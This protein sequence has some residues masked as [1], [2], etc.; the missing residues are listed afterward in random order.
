MKKSLVICLSIFLTLTS[1]SQQLSEASQRVFKSAENMQSVINLNKISQTG[2]TFDTRYEGVKGSP[3]LAD[4]LLPSFLKLAG[5]DYYFEI[6][7]DLD[8]A[9][10]ALIY[11]GSG[12]GQMYSIPSSDVSEL[13]INKGGYELVFRTTK[14]KKFEKD[15]KENRFYQV[16]SEGE[17]EFIKVPM[18][19]FIR[20]DYQGAYTADRRYDEYVDE[21]RYYLKG[22]DGTYHQVQL[23]KKSLIKL[24]PEKKEIIGQAFSKGSSEDKEALVMSILEQD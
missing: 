22:R 6:R 15:L 2:I 1:W 4:T 7:A 14:G 11:A 5:Q 23:N 13:V 3:R 9:N 17:Y 10:N 19:G 18:K 24:I 21:T 16:L 8:L 12:S 20:A